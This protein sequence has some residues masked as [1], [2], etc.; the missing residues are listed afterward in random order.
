MRRHRTT[1]LLALSIPFLPTCSAPPDERVASAEDVSMSEDPFLWLEGVSTERSLAWA[2]EHNAKCENQ[3]VDDSFRSL[4][5][6]LKAQLDSDAKIPSVRKIG[7]HYYN[8]WTDARNPR[9]LWRRTTPTDYEREDPAWET[10]LDLDALGRAEGKSWVWHGADVLAPDDRLCLISLSPGGSDADVVREFDLERK[11]FV[12]GGFELP[13]AKSGVSWRDRDSLWVGTDFGPGSLTES[14]YPRT[15]RLWRRGTPLASAELVFE[16]LKQDVRV[17]VTHD[18]T[19]GFERDFALRAPSFF[20]NEMSLWSD[21]RWVKVRKPDDA[22]ATPWRE[23]LLLELR[24]DWSVQGQRFEA[25]SL[26]VT[27]LADSLTDAASYEVLFTPGERVSLASITPTRNHVIVATLD[28]VKSRL[29]VLTPGASGWT[30]A[31][32]AGLP[33]F[34]ELSVRAIDSEES[35]DYF[36]GV[37]DFVMPPSLLAGTLG[38]SAPKLLKSAPAFFDVTGLVVSQHQALSQ[39]GT[40]IPYF[41]VRRAD[42]PLDGSAP[43]LL[44]AY[45]GFEVSLTPHYDGIVGAAWLEAGGVYV[46]ANIRGGG[47]FGPKWHQAALKQNRMRCYEDVAA[48]ARDLCARNV[49]CASRLGVMGGS[50]G[51]LMVGNMITH[52]PAL[53]G[54]AVCAV[55]LL[56]MR[57][58]HELLAGASWMGEYG[59]PDDPAQWEFI[60]GFSPYHNVHA[61]R[62]YPHTL[63]YTSTKDDRVHPGHARKMVARMEAQGHDVLYYENIEG[64][65]GAAADN[66]QR[67]F[68]STLAY[69]FLWRELGE[70]Q[71]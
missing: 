60:R 25:G 38:G 58:Y 30:Q 16:G 59:D 46:L 33:E 64:G 37:N 57:R 43:T 48:V 52:Y 40:R 53:F 23:W 54:A 22:N 41:E 3:L 63:F 61:G 17:A 39:D 5:A 34:G 70:P 10:V 50:N 51:G 55:P 27:K 12:A 42:A 56:D 47:E 20:T 44:E 4:E 9:G 13:E 1:L 28:E 24:S 19:P 29:A 2:R 7:A 14:G 15:V 45:G 6:R 62:A 49:T 68:M 71:D 35:D 8:L 69:R 67:A 32:M 36:L 18:S 66:A 31:P 65:H 21:G 26:L 11:A